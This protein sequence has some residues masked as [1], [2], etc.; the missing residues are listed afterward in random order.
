M[1][2]LALLLPLLALPCP[3]PP[4][5][6]TRHTID[7]ASHGAD[8]VRLADLDGDGDPDVATGW[9]EG[10][11]IR[12]CLNPGPAAS[13]RPWP[14]VTV[15]RVR[16]PEDAVIV[17]LDGDGRPE[18]VSCSEGSTRTVHIHR[19]PDDPAALLDPDAWRTAPIPATAGRS[20]WMWCAPMQV[21]GRRGVDLVLGGKGIGAAIGWLESPEDP[22]DLD[23]WSWHPIRPAGWIMTIRP[24]DLDLDGDL[25]LLCSDRKG[26]ARGVFWLERRASPTLPE[27]HEHPIGGLDSEVMFLDLADLDGDGSA[28]VIAAA[29]DRGLWIFR[30]RGT[31]SDPWEALTIP[32]GRDTGTGKAV[33]AGDLDGDGRPELVVTTENAAGKHGVVRLSRSAGSDLAGPWTATTISGTAIGTKFDLVVPIDLDADGDLDVLTCEERDDLGVFWYENPGR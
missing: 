29:R 32:L 9:E 20:M 28:E 26:S 5:G 8:G 27:W 7:S 15:G 3:G 6:W 12:V 13:K 30:R 24:I 14:A 11:A 23:A 19:A 1:S 4:E 18:V 2:P 16:N 31:A 25:D 10:G 17:D 33:A 22:A 21:D